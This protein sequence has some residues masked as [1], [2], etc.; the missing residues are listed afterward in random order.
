MDSS[1]EYKIQRLNLLAFPRNSIPKC[2]LTGE[3]ANVELITQH[4]TLYYATE[5]LAEQAWLGIIKK[6]AHL[7]PPLT[8]PAPIVG[9]QEERQKRV[10]NMNVSKRSLIDFCLLES[11]NMLSA[12]KYQLSFPAAYQALKFCKD[13]DG[14]KAISLVE[15]YMQLSQS[16]LGLKQFSKA[17]E[18]LSLAR[19]IVLNTP[20]CSDKIKTRL[21]M[22]KG[23]V[24]ISQGNHDESKKDFA[25]SIYYSSRCYGAESI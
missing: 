19:W 20:T 4:I 17:E 8:Q 12:Q 3:R 7:L 21:H 9:T 13:I 25:H 16:C 10:N 24:A 5:E 15:P 11:L 23:R 14:D 22:L 6:I 18:Y 1:I 2:E